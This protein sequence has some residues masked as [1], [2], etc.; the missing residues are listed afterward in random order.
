MKISKFCFN[1]KKN[2][3][4]IMDKICIGCKLKELDNKYICGACNTFRNVKPIDYFKNKDYFSLFNISSKYKIDENIL[5]ARYKELQK[6]VHPDKYA[7]SSDET[8]NEAQNLS[9]YISNAYQVLK[10]YYKR[11]NYIVILKLIYSCH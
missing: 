4:E 8:V 5:D 2:V 3:N 9:A 7:I 11:A 1:T 6:I 10:D